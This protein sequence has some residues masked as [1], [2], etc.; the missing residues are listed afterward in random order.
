MQQQP[1]TTQVARTLSVV[2]GTLAER[3]IKVR[4]IDMR[5]VSV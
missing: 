1:Q 3:K 5:T 4:G 2:Q